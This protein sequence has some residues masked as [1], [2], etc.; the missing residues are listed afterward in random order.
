MALDL[1]NP[2]FILDIDY[3]EYIPQDPKEFEKALEDGTTEVLVHLKNGTVIDATKPICVK[4]ADETRI[5]LKIPNPCNHKPLV[6]YVE[7]Y[8]ARLVRAI[9]MPKGIMIPYYE[10]TELQLKQPQ[11]E[12]FCSLP[13]NLIEYLDGFEVFSQLGDDFV[14]DLKP[15]LTG[16]LSTEK[17]TERNRRLDIL[18]SKEFAAYA[19]VTRFIC[20]SDPHQ[21]NFGSVTLESKKASDPA[22]T[23]FAAI[24]FDMAPIPLLLSQ[25]LFGP[26]NAY[27]VEQGS[28]MYDLG[29]LDLNQFPEERSVSP[30]NWITNWC[31]NFNKGLQDNKKKESDFRK[32]L[33]ATFKY[34]VNLDSL[35][36]RGISAEILQQAR[37]RNAPDVLQL[38]GQLEDFF[39]EITQKLGLVFPLIQ[40]YNDADQLDASEAST[41]I[42]EQSPFHGGGSFHSPH[43][44]SN[45]QKF[46]APPPPLTTLKATPG[47]QIGL[48]QSIRIDGNDKG[49]FPK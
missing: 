31:H 41:S 21:E 12:A 42:N 30:D 39:T 46:F 40:P 1:D 3:I 7:A 24:D 27:F 37:K 22:R 23:Y 33:L 45:R 2:P 49:A 44:D 8:V 35:F 17:L 29:T 16:R 26:A 38:F 47:Y 5:V 32:E 28:T 20:N 18:F 48:S 13:C 10:L 11:E 4:T 25:N 34:L 19:A 6:A 36:F 9:L 15:A 43:V 14:A